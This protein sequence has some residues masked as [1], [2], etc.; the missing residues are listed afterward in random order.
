M[1][2]E[3]CNE[4]EDDVSEGSG[5]FVNRIPSTNTIEERKRM[6]KPHPKGD[7]ICRECE[8]EINA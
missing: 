6:N 3:I 4:C 8:N 5:K 1:T 7:Y 2:K